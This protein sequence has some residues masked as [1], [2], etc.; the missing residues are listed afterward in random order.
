MA[1]NGTHAH[2][3]QDPAPAPGASLRG[4]SLW[5]WLQVL[6][7]PL[8][9]LLIGTGFTFLQG[10][11]QRA[12]EERRAES[13]A[14]QAYLTEMST[15]MMD[16]G[17]LKAD[18][19]DEARVLARARTVTVLARLEASPRSSDSGKEQVVEFLI[20]ADLVQGKDGG[21][22]VVSLEETDLNGIDLDN[23]D[24]RG[25]ILENAELRF[26]DLAGADLRGANLEDAH[27]LG[28]DLKGAKLGGATMPDGSRQ[29]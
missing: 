23:E 26:A 4:R 11:T 29:P 10:W 21:E 5:E 25:A 12:V 22:P 17:L 7:V 6:V 9:L 16:R 27:L 3:D 15:L 20:E 18:R 19:N 2:K 1:E 28:A 13:E 14:V 8:M 24:L